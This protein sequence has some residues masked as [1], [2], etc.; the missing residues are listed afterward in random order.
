M[1][2]AEI[3]TRAAA[4]QSVE[5][6]GAARHGQLSAAVKIHASEVEASATT[7]KRLS[8]MVRV[9]AS[10]ETQSG[11]EHRDRALADMDA[12][13]QILF[14]NMTSLERTVAG[15]TE[16]RLL[17]FQ[18]AIVVRLGFFDAELARLKHAPPVLSITAI[19]NVVAAVLAKHPCAQSERGAP[20]HST[21]TDQSLLAS[22]SALHGA[23]YHDISATVL[24]SHT[25]FGIH[26]VKF[27]P[28]SL[29]TPS[30]CSAMILLLSN[31]PSWPPYLS[32]H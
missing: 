12:R 7:V 18:T 1:L 2:R 19:S 24:R 28:C 27:I 26:C 5:L 4:V 31:H 13:L 14:Q 22:S 16:T 15:A 30:R 25:I 32:P 17:D 23:S 29:P 20:H 6:N 21:P 11:R 3:S 10:A 9:L 8:E